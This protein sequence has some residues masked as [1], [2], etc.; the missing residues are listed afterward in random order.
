MEV[1]TRLSSSEV[2]PTRRSAR[3]A[4]GDDGTTDTDEDSLAKAMRR[5]AVQNLDNE[6]YL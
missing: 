4:V 3:H 6:G 2:T 1:P 5:K